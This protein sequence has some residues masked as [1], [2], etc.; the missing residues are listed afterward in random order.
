MEHWA[1]TVKNAHPAF[2]WKGTMGN[3]RL[4]EK[5]GVNPSLGVCYYCNKE[6]GE[7]ILP[8]RLRD[9]QEAPRRAIWHTHPC[10]ECKGWMAK[11]IIFISVK[12]GDQD[13]Y[14]PHRTGM[15]TVVKTEA[16]ERMKAFIN[17][18]VIDDILKR[19]VAFLEDAVWD[20]VG[21]PRKDVPATE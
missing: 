7:I 9:D 5:H 20:A 19:R 8:G 6:N 12:D 17:I 1:G 11:G 16:V 14:N 18:Q 15:W 21:L 3:I 13:H 4:S 2:Y 10:D